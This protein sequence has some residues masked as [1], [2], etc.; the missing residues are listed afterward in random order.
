MAKKL[1]VGE[2]AKRAEAGITQRRDTDLLKPLLAAGIGLSIAFAAICA[3]Q[4]IAAFNASL[5][6]AGA[7]NLAQ[8]LSSEL[9]EEVKTSKAKLEKA[10]QSAE[11]AQH[12]MMAES[13][14][15]ASARERLMKLIPDSVDA[16]VIRGEDVAQALGG[17]FA[18]FG[19][20]KTDVLL[21][22]QEQGKNVPAQLHIEKDKSY[23]LVIATPVVRGE[24]R[25]GYVLAKFS[26]KK[27]I[28][29]YEAYYY[30]ILNRH[31]AQKE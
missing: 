17:R 29:Q 14:D 9:A 6:V 28:P 8:A 1:T 25:L 7:E 5:S 10:T 26:A 22:A 24:S 27:I 18:E 21:E 31:L 12:L 30:K 4:T 20:A 13:F 15:A 23:N 16:D 2:L 19:F 11:I 3:W